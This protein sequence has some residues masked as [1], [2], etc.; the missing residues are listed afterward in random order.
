MKA[1][2]FEQTIDEMIKALKVDSEKIYNYRYLISRIIDAQKSKKL[3]I[4]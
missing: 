3:K 2:S 1:E 4:N